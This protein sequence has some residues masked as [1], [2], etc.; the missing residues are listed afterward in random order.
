LD[1]PVTSREAKV[2]DLEVLV[3]EKLYAV[4]Y[5]VLVE[6]RAPVLIEFLEEEVSQIAREQFEWVLPS[7]G[8]FL[9]ASE[10]GGWK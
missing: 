5:F 4:N 8:T 9:E 1:I 10:K 3:D 7:L 6:V 2:K